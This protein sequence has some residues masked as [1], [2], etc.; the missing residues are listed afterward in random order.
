MG[1]AKPVTQVAG[2]AAFGGTLE[3]AASFESQFGKALESKDRIAPK[4]LRSQEWL[5]FFCRG[6]LI[7]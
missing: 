1:T 4:S 2:F 6:R 7:L 5:Q 3:A